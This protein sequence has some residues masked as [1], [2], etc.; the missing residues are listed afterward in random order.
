MIAALPLGLP[1]GGIRGWEVKR[2]CDI[3]KEVLDNVL[4]DEGKTM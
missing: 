4:L 2:K 3:A 1:Q